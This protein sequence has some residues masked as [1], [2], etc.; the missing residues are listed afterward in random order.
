MSIKKREEAKVIGDER[1]N[2]L[3]QSSGR[4]SV[5]PWTLRR[6][7]DSGDIRA[8]RVGRRVLIP[9]SELLRIMRDGCGS[10]AQSAAVPC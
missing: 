9:E 10:H 1:L 5:S 8:V 3:E 2:D 7:I 6:L 4:L